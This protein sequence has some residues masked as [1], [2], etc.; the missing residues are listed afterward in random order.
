MSSVLV[1]REVGSPAKAEVT[2]LALHGYGGDC[3]QLEALCG[4][5]SPPVAAVLP[6]AWRPLKAHGF[7]FDDEPGQ[8]WYFS[9]GGD[10][11][12]P[13][14]FGASLM[15]LE[16]FVHE[17]LDR[18]GA[19][20]PLFL[21]GY[22]QGAVLALALAQVVPDYLAGIVA[23]C[24][25]LPTIRGW[26]PPISDLQELPVLLID[27]PTQ[28][29]SPIARWRACGDRVNQLHAR[30]VFRW[31]SGVRSK[32]L[33]ATSHINDWLQSQLDRLE[34]NASTKEA[35]IARRSHC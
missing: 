2:V 5:L 30:A 28:A 11:P 3:K 10:R 9:F 25:Y 7:A 16:Q 21:I 31:V 12:E 35:G 6:Q 19:G 1:F 26:S 15:E 13:A 33:L 29:E 17:V 8:T 24:G 18:R 23:I 32:P 27:D 34:R 14:T 22:D 20:K 4:A